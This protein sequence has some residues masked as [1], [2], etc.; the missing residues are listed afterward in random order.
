MPILEWISENGKEITLNVRS[1][2]TVVMEGGQ[3]SYTFDFEGRLMGAFIHGKNYRRGMDNEV[4]EKASGE[5]PGLAGRLRRN[6][7]RSEVRELED[8]AYSFMRQRNAELASGR[9]LAEQNAVA[10]EQARE[11]FARIDRFN[12]DR[13]EIERETFHRIYKPVTIL[14]PDQYLALYLQA[15]EGCSFNSC[16]FCD[17]YQDRHFRVKSLNEFRDHI[18]R[19]RTFFG[20]S[21]LVR[22]SL[23]LGDANALLIPQSALLPLFD[24]LNTEFTIVPHGMTVEAR[25]EWKREHP[26]HFNG[27]YSFIDAFT[28]R[29]KTAEDYKALAE[30]G[31]RRVYVGL[32]TGDA[33]LLH[34][35]GKPN[36]P[37]E[38]VELANHVKAGGLGLGIIVLVGAGG[39]KFAEAHAKN[40]ARILNAMP[41]DENDIIY[42]SE[43]VD[44]PGSA[45]SAIIREAGISPLTFEE[46][47][48]QMVRMRTGLEFAQPNNAPKVSY[49]DIRE[50][51]Y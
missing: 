15:T 33:E 38:V 9:M 45:Y 18:R 16:A 21:A 37:L 29:R 8:R 32:E 30:R 7:E 39:D 40:T 35:L 19:V 50:F 31:L 4:L 28:T 14:P 23:F 17:F 22:Q 46:I 43:L 11:A 48:H 20:G 42:F 1:E 10:I 13:L 47:Q 41:L 3:L 36:T 27:I 51:I 34:F 25:A 2:S 24:T 44:S 26:N 49:Y 12:F 5:R 6:L